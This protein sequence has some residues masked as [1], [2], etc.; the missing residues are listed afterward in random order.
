MRW[1]VESEG[2]GPYDGRMLRAYRKM[3]TGRPS[4]QLVLGS[5]KIKR[6]IC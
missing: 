3:R 1:V 5:E 4:F 6:I 2:R